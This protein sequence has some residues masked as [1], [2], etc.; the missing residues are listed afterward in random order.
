M[1]IHI[2]GLDLAWGERRPDGICLMEATRRHARITHVGLSHGDRPLL[3]WLDTTIGSRAGLLAVDAPLVCV[4]ETGARPVDG[5]THVHFGRYK[6]GCHPTNSIRQVRPLWLAREFAARGYALDWRLPV[7]RQRPRLAFEVY[8]HPAIVR[9]CGL[10]ERIPYKRGPVIA[11]RAEFERLQDCLRKCFAEHFPMLEV[12]AEVA[13]L[14][15][16][17]WTK[18]VEDQTDALVCALIGY[19]HWLH[20]GARSQVLG[21]RETGFLVVPS[22]GDGRGE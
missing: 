9:L 12:G 11:R 18:D 13:A 10:S 3:D 14:L 22:V 16:L 8:P 6:C 5:L 17:P 20:R 19:W 4:N 1:T 7:G 15:T 21:N 2:A